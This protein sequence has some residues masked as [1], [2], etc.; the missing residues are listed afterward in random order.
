MAPILLTPN[1]LQLIVDIYLLL[2][3]VG[4]GYLTTKGLF[5]L[6]PQNKAWCISSAIACSAIIVLQ[7]FLYA[8]DTP[9]FPIGMHH[10]L[11]RSACVALTDCGFT[12]VTTFAVFCSIFHKVL[13]KNCL[14]TCS[15]VFHMF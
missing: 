13:K 1:K 10:V 2:R 6:A 12:I 14:S 3:D 9:L 7:P 11:G 15:I 4:K 5:L 8:W